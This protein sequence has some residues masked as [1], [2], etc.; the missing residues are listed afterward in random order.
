VPKGM[1]VAFVVSSQIILL[2][3]SR[4]PDIRRQH[5]ADSFIMNLRNELHL[6][7]VSKIVVN[8]GENQFGVLTNDTKCSIAGMRW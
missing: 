5:N 3:T 8:R 4:H 6:K 2:H 1:F 7:R